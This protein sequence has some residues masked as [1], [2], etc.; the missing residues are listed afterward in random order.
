MN[1]G[2]YLKSVLL[3]LLVA[4][5]KTQSGGQQSI[6]TQ[7]GPEMGYLLYVY[8]NLSHENKVVGRECKF[9]L[10]KDFEVF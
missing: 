7:R 1:I 4:S 9:M 8:P 2:N 6:C 5:P 3:N 10:V